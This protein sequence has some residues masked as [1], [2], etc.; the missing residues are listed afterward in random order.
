MDDSSNDVGRAILMRK[1]AFRA[2]RPDCTLTESEMDC[3][4]AKFGEFENV[5]EFDL[6]AA[7]NWYFRKLMD[8]AIE[9]R[10][11]EIDSRLTK[12]RLK[13]STTV[14]RDMKRIQE[15]CEKLDAELSKMDPATRTWLDQLLSMNRPKDDS[16]QGLRFRAL[17]EQID[18]PMNFLIHAAHKAENL[19]SSGPNNAALRIMV[20]NLA[21]C[22]EKC[23][24]SLPTTDK[25]RG[26]QEDPFLELCREMA[27]IVHARLK[28]K[29]G[30]L[31]ALQLSGIVADVLKKIGRAE[32]KVDDGRS[33]SR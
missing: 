27:G 24:G 4:A 26:R 15:A 32:P 16:G 6:R 19:A 28:V 8:M 29:G 12:K 9:E 18:Q 3:L 10:F 1:K 21:F 22:W 7:F 11:H 23:H 2:A 17:E 33:Y 20:E 30:Q 5:A 13:L 31:G 25:G 14:A